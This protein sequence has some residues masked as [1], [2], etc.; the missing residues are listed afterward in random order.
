MR[1]LDEATFDRLYE[2]EMQPTEAAVSLLCTS[3]D[4]PS[5]TVYVVV[6]TAYVRPEEAE[7]TEGR[8]LVFEVGE[9]SSG[10][11][12]RHE[13]AT[14]GA[15]YALEEFRGQLLAG[16]NNKLQLYSW[17]SLTEASSASLV[18]RHEHCGHILVLYV[19]SRG[20]FILVGDLMKSLALLQYSATT[21]ELNEL[22]RDYNANWMTAVAFLDDEAFLGAE[23]GFNLFVAR[24]NSDA[25][26]DEERHRLDVVGEFHIGEFVNRFR[27]GSLTMH[28]AEGG[29][30]PLPTILFGTVNGVLGVLASL[31]QS[32]YSFLSKVV[33][34]LVKVIKG[35]G[36]LVHREYRSFS[37]ERKTVEASGFIDGDLLEGYLEL[38]PH[39]KLEVVQG[40]EVTVEE[41]TRQVEELARLH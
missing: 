19:Q 28:V 26:T 9:R 3:F 10:L 25:A 40:L 37:N 36:G 21:G 4:G 13:Y 7:P 22:A 24:K 35:V 29:T 16:V 12:L 14:K 18:L 2:Y 17:S 8:L 34:N 1:L 38:S 41:L 39:Q 30:A 23:N 15:V 32:Q 11:E 27:K 33:G 20:D 5:S 6:G 31:S